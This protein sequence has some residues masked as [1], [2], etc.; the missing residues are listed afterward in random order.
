MTESTQDLAWMKQ[1]IQE[2]IGITYTCTLHSDNQSAISIASN[3]IYH[4]GTRHI[5]FCLHFIRNHLQTNLLRLKYLPTADMLADL[6]T[7]NLPIAKTLPHLKIILSNPEL[8]STG[9]Y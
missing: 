6:L 3:P 4:H 2:A 8:T 7:K 9:E 1:I 5:E